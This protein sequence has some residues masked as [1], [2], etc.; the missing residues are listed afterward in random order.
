MTLPAFG[1]RI[2]FCRYSPL[3]Y[4]FK[5]LSSWAA[6]SSIPQWSSPLKVEQKNDLDEE[7]PAQDKTRFHLNEALSTGAPWCPA[8]WQGCD[9]G[10]KSLSSYKSGF[11][12]DMTQAFQRLAC[13]AGSPRPAGRKHWGELSTRHQHQPIQGTP[14][15]CLLIS[16]SPASVISPS[17]A[18]WGKALKN[19]KSVLQPTTL[20]SKALPW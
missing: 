14:K 20:V 16:Y 9:V 7:H 8:L 1:T 3:L 10:R 5:T 6:V 11:T 18:H 4:R 17:D 13:P 2:V 19:L 12:P 15:L